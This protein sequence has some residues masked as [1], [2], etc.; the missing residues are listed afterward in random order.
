MTGDEAYARRLALSQGRVPNAP[1][2]S[3]VPSA[4]T[5]T[6]S[7][8]PPA[9]TADEVD[10]PRLGMGMPQMQPQPPAAPQYSPPSPPTLAYNP[11]APPSVPPPPPGGFGVPPPDTAT[12]EFEERV[13]SSREAAAAVA[14]R[15]AQLAALEPANSGE[16]SSATSEKEKSVLLHIYLRPAQ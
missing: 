16:G 12:T 13:R 3:V 7:V 11:F 15:L 10:E 9:E 2:A 14:A 5:P 1:A 8:P 6:P 4:P